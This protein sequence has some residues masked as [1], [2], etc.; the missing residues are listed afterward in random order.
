MSDAFQAFPARQLQ[1]VADTSMPD[2]SGLIYPMLPVC[3]VDDLATGFQGATFTV[4]HP[5]SNWVE[6]DAG[7]TLAYGEHP[8]HGGGKVEATITL[9]AERRAT[10]TELMPQG[11]NTDPHRLERLKAVGTKKMSELP[12]ILERITQRYIFNSANYATTVDVSG[13]GGDLSEL[14]PAQNIF[15]TIYEALRSNDLL[16]YRGLF[17]ASLEAF[18]YREDLPILGEYLELTGVL[19]REGVVLDSMDASAAKR[20]N[21][22]LRGGDA[23]IVAALQQRFG[24]DRVNVFTHA[25]NVRRI[26]GAGGTVNGMSKPNA[27]VNGGFITGSM[28][29]SLIDRA[30][31]SYNLRRDDGLIIK[32]RFG[33]VLTTAGNSVQPQLRSYLD[34]KGR[35]EEVWAE[36]SFGINDITTLVQAAAPGEFDDVPKGIL[37]HGITAA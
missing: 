2:L 31:S 28:F 29:V 9:T 37:F 1:R 7:H 8:R 23:A 4:Q 10:N 22:G 14:D 27:D 21:P 3:L 33:P 13:T 35:V 36:C 17:G 15:V 20:L 26:N 25:P 16:R 32:P 5:L 12:Q 19:G 34:T 6:D 24:F 11:F 18:V 30:A